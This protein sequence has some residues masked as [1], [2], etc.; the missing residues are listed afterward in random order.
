MSELFIFNTL[1]GKKELFES[2]TPNE[3]KMY[4]CGPTVYD[5]LHVGNF[6]GAVFYNFLRNWL[7]ELN[8]KVTYAYNFTDIDDKIL[9]RSQ[10]ES[11]DF[12]EII[13]TYI[14]AFWDDFNALKLKPHDLNPRVTENL[15][16]IIKII[17]QLIEN[18]SAYETN[19]EVFYSIASFK[20]YGKLSNRKTE[21]MISGSRVE[22]DPNKKN[23]LDFTLWKPAKEND[24]SWPSPWGDGRPGWHIECTAMIFEHLGQTIDIH[25][26]GLDLTFPHHENEIAQAEACSNKY[27][28]NYWVHNNMFTFSGS[29]MSKSLGNVR[30]MK[31]FLTEYHPEIF[32]YLVL[33]SHYRS[34]TEFS[35]KT[36][37][38]SI[39]GL[40][41]I[42]ESLKNAEYFLSKK[43]ADPIPSLKAPE[44]FNKLL[45]ST[46]AQMREAYNDDFNTSKAM[47]HVFDVVRQFNYLCPAGSGKTDE[48]FEIAKSYKIFILK[49]GKLLS[50]FLEE[51]STFL[52]AVDKIL[53]KRLNIDENKVTSL[54]NQRT[55]AKAQK[56]FAK[57]DEC[58]AQL[59]SLGIMVK[60]TP[61]GSF[62]EVDKKAII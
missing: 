1:S 38:N 22:P 19:G 41:R 18:G 39:S 61:E 44:E 49:Q 2:I 43:D 40:A 53:M 46:E 17:S 15:D 51:P 12:K 35:E 45:T 23:P 30:T 48:R 26:G 59:S 31:D 36:I 56:D 34:Q 10:D 52:T 29:K 3:V 28:A 33:S 7:E 5:Y 42:Y 32:K 62:W 58:R 4:C 47:S 27:Y 6:R 57:A 11:R 16:A 50:L 60:D 37:M 55:E 13:E 25:G 21:D 20:D 8:Y 54:M 14:Q 9:K 24:I